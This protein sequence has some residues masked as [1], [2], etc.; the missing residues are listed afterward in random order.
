MWHQ[1]LPSW[2]DLAARLLVLGIVILLGVG[3]RQMVAPF[4]AAQQPEISLSPASLPFY[5][6]DHAEG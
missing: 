3:A 6:L 5:G 4:V 1:R 2:R